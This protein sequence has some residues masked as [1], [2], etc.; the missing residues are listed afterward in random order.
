MTAQPSR[1][2]MRRRSSYDMHLRRN[3][4]ITMMDVLEGHPFNEDKGVGAMR[5]S[6]LVNGCNL[7]PQDIQEDLR[8]LGVDVDAKALQRMKDMGELHCYND[9]HT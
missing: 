8:H 5:A 1:S 7:D 3:S 2:A 9:S 4:G 6:D